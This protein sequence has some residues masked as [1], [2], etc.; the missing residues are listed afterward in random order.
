MLLL[1]GEE[2]SRAASSSEDP[3]EHFRLASRRSRP[4]KRAISSTTPRSPDH[5]RWVYDSFEPCLSGQ[6]SAIPVV[7]SDPEEG[8]DDRASR[9]LEDKNYD[10]IG[11]LYQASGNTE[12]FE[13]PSSKATRSSRASKTRGEGGVV[14]DSAP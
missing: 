1:A 5:G 11:A 8:R 9:Q 10:L 3:R 7:C 13:A 4:T 2:P 12:T 14:G 6:H